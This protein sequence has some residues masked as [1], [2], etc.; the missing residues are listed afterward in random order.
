MHVAVSLL[1]YAPPA[2][3]WLGD[4]CAGVLPPLL[5]AP[6]IERA[7]LLVT[8][9]GYRYWQ[10][11]AS[12]RVQL[13]LVE[14][15]DERKRR[16]FYAER[17]ILPHMLRELQPDAVFAPLGGSLI[18]P[19]AR[20]IYRLA[21]LAYLQ[22]PEHFSLLEQLFYGK[23]IPASCKVADVIAVDHAALGEAAAERNLAS[24]DRIHIAPPGYALPWQAAGGA[25]TTAGG[26]PLPP[27]RY[28]LLLAGE[29]NAQL[30]RLL[31]GL[32]TH[33]RLPRG[34]EETTFVCLG[35][36][37]GE[38]SGP[39]LLAIEEA[40]AEVYQQLLSGA[41]LALCLDSSD[42]ALPAL[43]Q[44]LGAGLPV[45]AVDTPASRSIGGGAAIY[46]P[47][48]EL[49]ETASALAVLL[50][51]DKQRSEL[52]NKAGELAQTNTWKAA[53]QH[54]LEVLRS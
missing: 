27:A 11:L 29:E 50:A 30:T 7:T 31:S 28:V 44:T 21:T 18:Q 16:R 32:L 53:A 41:A 46:V 38:V 54:V 36:Q 23:T 2:R 15:L 47:P 12:E 22:E 52:G 3:P 45:I 19:E 5:A 4:Y 37:A 17:Y 43:W 49:T 26:G 20:Y 34:W 8:P 33:T 40:P 10:A 14:G 51:D 42:A 6:Q 9:F 1:G 25:T 24:R 48:N 35:R 39:R 13:R